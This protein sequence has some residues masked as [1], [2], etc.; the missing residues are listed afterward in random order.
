MHLDL[1]DSP[2]ALGDEA[3]KNAPSVKFTKANGY[4]WCCDKCSWCE[5]ITAQDGEP[6]DPIAAIES[7]RTHRCED[8]PKRAATA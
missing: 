6:R 7:Y 1:V 4:C 5:P 3:A 8:Y 2:T